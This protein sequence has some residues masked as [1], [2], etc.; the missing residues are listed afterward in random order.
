MYIYI[1]IYYHS[2]YYDYALT[3]SFA[4]ESNGHKM[5]IYLKIT[6]NTRWFASHE[7]ICCDI[8]HAIRI[9]LLMHGNCTT[10]GYIKYHVG[11]LFC[12]NNQLYSYIIM[13]VQCSS[14]SEVHG[15]IDTSPC[16]SNIQSWPRGNEGLA[17][18]VGL[19]HASRAGP[20]HPRSG[21][22]LPRS[23]VGQV[24]SPEY[25]RKH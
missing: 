25:S 8:D 3:Q 11:S 13:L 10:I 7:H 5:H 1:I 16:R 19:A 20:C 12:F 2:Y 15:S 9:K 4:Q 18:L 14:I 6:I 21:G 17:A 24:G 22:I 23:S